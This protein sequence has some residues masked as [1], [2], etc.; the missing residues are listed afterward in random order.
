MPIADA[1]AT[2]PCPHCGHAQRGE[3]YETIAARLPA[4]LA[5]RVR[6]LADQRGITVSML[7]RETMTLA[8]SQ[9]TVR[10]AVR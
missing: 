8:L 2:R 7:I 6:H 9:Q 10:D 3:L 4:V 5:E 1:V